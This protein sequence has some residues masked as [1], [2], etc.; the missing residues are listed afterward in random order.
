MDLFVLFIELLFVVLFAATLAQYIQRRDPVSRAVTLTF[1]AVTALF[2]VSLIGRFVADPPRALVIPAVF[3]FFLHLV[4]LVRRVPPWVQAAS[5]VAV[6]GTAVPLFAIRPAS[7]A[8][9]VVALSVFAGIE[10]L[11]AISLLLAPRRRLGPVQ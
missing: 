7:A 6:V 5:L 10:L 3:L 11:A 1:S 9:A 2:V 8:L 4:S